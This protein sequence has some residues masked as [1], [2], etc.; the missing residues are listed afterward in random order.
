MS[1]QLFTYSSCFITQ[2]VLYTL[3]LFLII[4]SPIL[5]YYLLSSAAS[6][7]HSLF[8]SLQPSL[9]FIS[10][11]LLIFFSLFLCSLFFL[12]FFFSLP[13]PLL[14]CNLSSFILSS[15]FFCSLFSGNSRSF[16][17]LFSLFQ[18]FNVI[19]FK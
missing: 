1:I 6:L 2:S 3:C 5:P 8:L 7:L 14:L 15:F 10:F 18:F 11:P 19:F 17:F 16:C 12:S 9:F 4:S 13:L